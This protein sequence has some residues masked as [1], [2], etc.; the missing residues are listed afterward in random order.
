MKKII[1]LLMVLII[2]ICKI[3]EAQI[4]SNVSLIKNLNPRPSQTP[5]QFG[6]IYAAL[7]GYTATDG[8]E[9]AILGCVTGTSFIDITDSLNVHEVGFLPGLYSPWRE[10]KTYQNYAYI[11]SDNAGVGLQI[12]DLQYLPDSIHHVRNWTFG[13]FNLAHAITQE[14]R[15]LYLSGGNAAS[16]GG[17]RIVDLLDP[18][19]PVARGQYTTRYSHDC[20]VRNDTIYAA[21]M[22]SNRY[23]ILN[24]TNKDNITTIVEIQNLPQ[25]SLTHNCY[26]SDDRKYLYTSDES[27]SPPGSLKVWDIQNYSNIQYVEMIRP[28]VPPGNNAIVHNVVVDGNLLAVSHYEAGIWFYDISMPGSPS[29]LGYYDTYST[30]NNNEYRGNWGNYP[31]FASGKIIAS[32]MQTGLWVLRLENRPSGIKSGFTPLNGYKLEQNF[33]NPFN[34]VTNIGFSIPKNSFVELKIFDIT[35]K[36]VAEVVNDRRDAGNYTV[37]FDAS[38]YSSGTYFYTLTAGEFKETRKMIIL[39]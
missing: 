19:N 23:G 13:G 4:S 33:P 37:R 14:G 26:I 39:K 22:F 1:F 32:D 36:E 28:T 6:S 20:F 25:Y 38:E 8:R 10:I 27:Q 2:G 35:G 11:V 9:Y 21:L 17:I 16:N 30:S 15:F 5:S 29:L 31:Y 7:W 3:S 34:P 24:A 12:V 18:V